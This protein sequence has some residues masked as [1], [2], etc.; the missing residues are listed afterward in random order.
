[1]VFHLTA[2][3]SLGQEPGSEPATAHIGPVHLTPTLIIENFGYDS[4][5]F[6]SVDAPKSDFVFTVIPQIAGQVVVRRALFSFRSDT[7][8]QYFATYEAE[9]SVNEDLTAGGRWSL[10]RLT[11]TGNTSYLN[12]R[13]RPNDEID[14]RS[15]RVEHNND[16]GIRAQLTPKLS[17]D[18]RLR[19]NQVRFDADPIFDAT[20]LA[21][22]MNRNE[23]YVTTTVRYAITPLT[24][25]FTAGQALEERFILS[26]VRD[27]DSTRVVGGVEL[28]P[29]ALLSG[30]ASVGY[31]RFRPE[32]TAL[33]G[34]AGVV[35]TV[36]LSYRLGTSTNLTGSFDRHPDYSYAVLE[37]YYVLD[38]YGW[39][40]RRQ[41]V[42]RFDVEMRARR[43]WYHYQRFEQPSEPSNFAGRTDTF[44]TDTLALG[45]R[46]AG[47][48]RS[49]LGITYWRRRSDERDYNEFDG[50]QVGAT[51]VYRF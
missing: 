38:S 44:F 46:M 25:L 47:N 28:H 4:N 9:R 2:G 34:F 50:I 8:F 19:F 10:R 24:S 18:V 43:S 16:I 39:S 13:R 29:R 33:P 35:G 48:A 17:A 23:R 7:E 45:Y 31:Q 40:V 12:T 22:T 11:V 30:T 49:T 36:G 1:M 27:A 37:P 21:Q 14:A 6:R 20:S 51:V 41:L 3:T 15:R 42:A 26:P 5:V 32:S